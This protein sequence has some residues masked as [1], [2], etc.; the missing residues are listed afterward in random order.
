[1]ETKNLI[2]AMVNYNCDPYIIETEVEEKDVIEFLKKAEV[3]EYT[4]PD[5]EDFKEVCTRIGVQPT[6]IK[7][8]YMALQDCQQLYIGFEED[9]I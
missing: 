1:M 5:D 3:Y 9:L 4:N 8:V 7:K 6:E 2:G